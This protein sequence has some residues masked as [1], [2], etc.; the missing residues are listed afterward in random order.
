MAGLLLDEGDDL[1]RLV[2]DH[3]EEG[4]EVRRGDAVEAVDGVHREGL[5][6]A[7]VEHAGAQ[8]LQAACGGRVELEGHAEGV[9]QLGE[10]PPGL[11]HRGGRVPH[12]RNPQGRCPA[13]PRGE[14][15]QECGPL[16]ALEDVEVDDVHAVLPLE[17]LEDGLVRREVRKLYV[18]A[19]LQTSQSN[20]QKFNGNSF[21]VQQQSE[22][23][24]IESY[25]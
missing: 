20:E 19:H 9:R 18:G 12:P 5:A 16:V 24:T 6:D 22:C 3:G 8:V 23:E 2:A 14:R 21:H 1:G 4:A 25:T 15:L 11:A 13:G 7:A 10:V 17:G